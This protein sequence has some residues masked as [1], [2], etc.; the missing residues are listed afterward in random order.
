MSR[1]MTEYIEAANEIC[2]EISGKRPSSLSIRVILKRDFGA[3]ELKDQHDLLVR[4]VHI[5]FSHANL[6]YELVSEEELRARG[7]AKALARF[8]DKDQKRIAKAGRDHT[9][10]KYLKPLLRA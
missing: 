8:L 3:W 4:A 1:P 7:T 2:N 9:I 5:A 10:T 6:L